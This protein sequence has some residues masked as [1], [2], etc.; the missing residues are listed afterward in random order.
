MGINN[1]LGK[2]CSY[3]CVYSNVGRTL[4]MEVERISFYEPE[5]I[6][7]EVEGKV[8]RTREI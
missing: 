4:R 6:V 1:I 7:K 2:I 8:E 3:S 5:E